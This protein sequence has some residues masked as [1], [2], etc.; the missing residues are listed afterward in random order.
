MPLEGEAKKNYQREYMRDWR[1]RNRRAP[2]PGRDASTSSYEPEPEA[3]T[4]PAFKITL[5]ELRAAIERNPFF[6]EMG[7]YRTALRL[8][9]T[10]KI[11]P[12]M[13]CGGTPG[14][15]KT[16]ELIEATKA[17]LWK[18]GM[19][20][21]FIA[22]GTAPGDLVQEIYDHSGFKLIVFDDH[23]KL[24]RAPVAQEIIKA[25]WGPQRQIHWGT[26]ASKNLNQL[27][28]GNHPPSFEVNSIL[29]WLSNHDATKL[30]DGD[31]NLEA[32]FDRGLFRN[33]RGTTVELFRYTMHKALYETDFTK[34][35]SF[36]V[37]HQ[38][39][40]WFNYNRNRLRRLS[41][42][43]MMAALS[44]INNTDNEAE[45]DDALEL[46]LW[47]DPKRNIPGFEFSEIAEALAAQEPMYQRLPSPE[48]I[49]E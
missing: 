29:I 30:T 17:L 14:I 48:Q 27:L 4:A 40:Q 16:H 20:W 7:Q 39:I 2:P 9:L 38:A 15:G 35:F 42:R 12:L 49:G 41:L 28:R 18:Q 22:P 47:R 43:G 24:L 45:K 31:V 10:Y 32:I 21:N 5:D 37:K 8:I 34:G 11:E 13:F 1:R 23:D 6:W 44:Y 36:R 3:P 25:G 46:L 33:I 26:S 19:E